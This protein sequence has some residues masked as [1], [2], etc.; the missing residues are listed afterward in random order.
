MNIYPSISVVYDRKHL[1]T[2][3]REALVQIEI[4]YLRKRKY[5]STGVRLTKDLWDTRANRPINSRAMLPYTEAIEAHLQRIQSYINTL[6]RENEPFTWEGLD[7]FLSKNDNPKDI[8]F[9]GFIEERI[10]AR[11]MAASTKQTHER[12]IKV[13]QE[14]G[15]IQYLSDLTGANVRAFNDY[16]AAQGYTQVTIW[17]YHKRLKIYIHEAMAFRLLSDDPYKGF[18]IKRGNSNS[19]RYLTEDECTLLEQAEMLD[20]ATGRA[21]DLFVFCRYTGMAYSDLRAFDFK[22]VEK[23]GEKYI[24]RDYRIK[25]NTPYY[26]ELLPPA[27]EVL[28]KYN[29]K[30]PVMSNANYNRLLKFVALAAGTKPLTSHMARH[31]FA[32]WALSRGVALE[33]VSKMLGHTNIQTTQ[34]YAKVMGSDILK[35]FEKLK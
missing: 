10:N 2:N 13:L 27:I 28:K 26:V 31:T 8:Y 25:T 7:H 4:S 33:V 24:I 9:L 34:I 21:R 30:L 12:L 22:N 23:Q 19:I 15:K 29:Y 5:V 1:A 16:L 20:E 14:F 18:S 3:S 35:A 11:P 32:T 6:I 17:G